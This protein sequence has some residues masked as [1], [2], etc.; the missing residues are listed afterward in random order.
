ML[1]TRNLS[2]RS[3]DPVFNEGKEGILAY[4]TVENGET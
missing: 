3:G 1:G 2:K 4:S